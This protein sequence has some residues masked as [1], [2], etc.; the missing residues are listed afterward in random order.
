MAS[1]PWETGRY[2]GGIEV[3]KT[4]ITLRIYVRSR[5]DMLKCSIDTAD[6]ARRPRNGTSTP[7]SP[8]STRQLDAKSTS[9]LRA[10]RHS[11]SS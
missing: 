3:V 9:T 2:I 1:F 4:N 7:A 8:S 11:S 5:F 6:T 10:S